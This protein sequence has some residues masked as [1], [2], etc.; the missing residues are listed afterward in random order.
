MML[1]P[2]GGVKKEKR[3]KTKIKKNHQVRGQPVQTGGSQFGLINLEI[4]RKMDSF[5]SLE[6]SG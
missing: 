4:M 2:E 5:F 3:K 6:L 1:Q